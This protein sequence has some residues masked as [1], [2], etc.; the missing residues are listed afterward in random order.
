MSDFRAEVSQFL[1]T[2]GMLPTNLGKLAVGDGAFVSDLLTGGRNPRLDTVDRV[3]SWMKTYLADN[4][5]DYSDAASPL[6]SIQFTLPRPSPLLN[7]AL[8]THWQA[9]RRKLRTLAWE[10]KC[11]L[12]GRLPASPFMRAKLR[13][14]RYSIG[15]PD[16]DGVVGGCKPLIDCLLVASKVHPCSLGIIADDGPEHLK[17][18]VVPVKVATKAEQKTIVIIEELPSP[19]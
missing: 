17:L 5:R 2:T 11:L 15:T 19:P 1:S 7:R 14:E 3:T 18:E 10:V 12:T 6:R 13:I 9:R 8:R 16:F 4:E